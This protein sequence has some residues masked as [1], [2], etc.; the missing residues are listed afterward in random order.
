[1]GTTAIA[2]GSTAGVSDDPTDADPKE[3]G[4]DR[5]GLY[6]EVWDAPMTVVAQR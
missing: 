2:E 3:K 4:G 6:A 5:V 1:M